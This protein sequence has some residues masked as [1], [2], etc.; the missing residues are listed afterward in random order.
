MTN[1]QRSARNFE[2]QRARLGSR[3][4]LTL[5][6]MIFGIGVLRRG[7]AQGLAPASLDAQI[8]AARTPEDHAEI[9]R[10]LS[11]KA[12]E[13][14]REAASHRALALQYER[15][16]VWLSYRHHDRS[17]LRMAEHCR[18]V[19]ENCLQ[20]ADNLTSLA[21]AHERIGRSMEEDP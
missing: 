3:S 9:A 2:H 16:G 14:R 21:Q 7:C 20:A 4:P 15:S 6:L 8:E 19:A 12:N 17:D 11:A 18:L 10:V 1:N 5:V 13:Y